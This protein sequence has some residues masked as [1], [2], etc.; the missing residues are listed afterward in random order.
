MTRVPITE[1]PISC[2]ECGQPVPETGPRFGSAWT[3]SD[4]PPIERAYC[5]P[6]CFAK[7]Y[8]KATDPT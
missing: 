2:D 4:S 5:G 3:A 6:D 1:D 8:S 7:R